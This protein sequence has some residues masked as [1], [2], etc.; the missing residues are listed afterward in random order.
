[1]TG[2][3]TFDA[4]ILVGHATRL[5]GKFDL[6]IDRR[7][8]LDR[9]LEAVR[10]AGFT[11]TVVAVPGS[12]RAGPSVVIDRYDRGPLG[13]VRSFIEGRAGPFL[14]LGGDMPFV[15][16]EDL[17]L[18]RERFRLGRSV[19]PQHP[20]GTFEV[21]LA[22]Y[23]LPVE[24]VAGFW[25]E[26]R[27]LHDLVADRAEHGAVD[28]VPVGAFDPDS[29]VD[30]DTPEDYARWSRGSPPGPGVEPRG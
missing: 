1:M 29:F 9:V 11:P 8:V 7:S 12:V 19:V 20:D 28:I 6:R 30:L 25:S 4:A 27:S 13:G 21:L 10:S 26:G 18:L 24:Q 5:P 15:R 2:R 22:I 14:L 23:D 3:G 17:R 16:P